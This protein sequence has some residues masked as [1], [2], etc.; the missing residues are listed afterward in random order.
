[1]KKIS[2]LT[3]KTIKTIVMVIIIVMPWTSLIYG[4]HDILE[5]DAAAA[6]L[7]DAHRGQII[8][9]KNSN[10]KLHI[11]SANKIMT[12]LLA[13]ENEPRP[14]EAKVTVS[15]KAVAVEGA[16]SN[17]QVGD[18]YIVED[19]IYAVVL[20]PENDSTNAL[21][22]YIA[23]DIEP[24]VDLMNEKAKDLGMYD[25]IFANPTGLFHESQHTTANDMALL[26]RYALNNPG[27]ERVF[28]S[29]TWFWKDQDYRM[30]RNENRLFW[31][32]DGIDGGRIGF[33]DFN[34]KTSVTTATRD[35]MRLVSIV[36]DCP[37]ESLDNDTIKLLDYG[38]ENYK[39]S[40]LVSK[41]QLIDRKSI[42]D[43]IVD[44]ISIRD[45]YYVHPIGNS[46]LK[47][48]ELEF[49]NELAPPITVN[50]EVGIARYILDDDTVIEVKL[51]PSENVY[52]AVSFFSSLVEKMTQYREIT[53]LLIILIAIEIVLLIYKLI[54]MTIY[55]FNKILFKFKNSYK[56]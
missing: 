17:L 46:Y 39:R 42:G 37:D 22:E 8:Y 47:G 54:K 4:N 48:S 6:I 55:I 31:S 3:I 32:Y 27:F 23:G 21:A 15:R 51:Y 11:S 43:E 38:F 35:N 7:I 53:I 50:Q 24:F 28:S 1:M 19:L 25:T 34:R 40:V 49:E 33:N 56:T 41:G 12:A 26:I 18:Q 20:T 13:I 9:E 44:L 5:I 16:K 30:L 36:L 45:H 29:R 52:S 10:V 14:S 2:T